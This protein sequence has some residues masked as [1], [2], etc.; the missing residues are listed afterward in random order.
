MKSLQKLIVIILT[1]AMLIVCLAGTALAVEG[2][3]E[4]LQEG[5]LIR[6]VTG[7]DYVTPVAFMSS[8]NNWLNF[9]IY[10]TLF[11]YVDGDWNNI[12]GALARDWA[13]AEDGMSIVLNLVENATF[14]SG[15]PVTA[16]AV[17]RCFEYTA[18]YYP[19]YFD[20]IES[21]EA[22]GDYELTITFNAPYADF[23]SKFAI[24]FMSIV[25]PDA[26]DEFGD[27]S[28]E[29]AV[30]SGP[31]YI[32]DYVSGEKMVLKANTNYWDPEKYPHIETIEV[33]AINDDNTAMMSL[34]TGDIDYYEPANLDQV[35]NLEM[36]DEVYV[37]DGPK[38]NYCVWLNGT[39][40]TCPALADQRVREAIS[41][42]INWD[43]V[44]LIVYGGDA[45][46]LTSPWHKGCT[47]D[48]DEGTIYYDPDKA[49]ALLEEA[50]VKPEDIT[51][52]TITAPSTVKFDTAVAGQLTT[53]G[54]NVNINEYD[55]GG[56]M[57]NGAQGNW[58]I[59]ENGA[60]F[61]QAAPSFGFGT[62][63]AQSGAM[64]TF[65]LDPEDPAAIKVQEL[66][67]QANQAITIDEMNEY[68]KQCTS[69]IVKAYAFIGG[70]FK[71]N[72]GAFTNRLQGTY[73][74]NGY[75]YAIF[76]DAYIAE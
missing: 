31:Y 60:A 68:Y 57:A 51:L 4:G 74:E 35:D 41:H 1:V 76:F 22:T 23:T 73:I 24:S 61:T 16:D 43:E 59:W 28:L 25:D 13:W 53:Y 30:G 64:R 17:K 33:L 21:I 58:D 44:N 48:V 18:Q 36:Y 62:M 47:V 32:A 37:I 14:V 72:W 46:T 15:R 63:I 27:N 71:P 40:A 45:E 66:Y 55:I 39:S 67:E 5:T 52:N 2:E 19:S 29:G 6:V 3:P 10:D 12:R 8:S 49:L 38:S 54:I 20:K 7:D 50:G 42:L 34:I 65:M 69:E 11:T 70:L 26:L 75:R 9:H 56:A